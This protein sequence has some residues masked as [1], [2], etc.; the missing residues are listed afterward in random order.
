MRLK[1]HKH[2]IFLY[3]FAETESL[4]SQGPV[5]RDLLK[6]YSIRLRYSTFKH[7]R[8]CSVS[9]EIISTHAQPVF[10]LFPYNAQGAIKSIPRTLSIDVHV[11]TDKN[12]S[13]G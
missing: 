2:E 8:L 12:F 3:F 4:W 10:K 1:A 13:A 9:D 6:S 7:C 5:T 11:K